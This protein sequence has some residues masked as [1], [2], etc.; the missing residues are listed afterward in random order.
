MAEVII[1][2]LSLMIRL[3]DTTNGNLIYE[4]NVIFRQNGEQIRLQQHRSG[5]WI[6][7]N[8][9]RENCIL[10][11]SVYG[12][13][14][15]EFAVDYEQLETNLPVKEVFLIPKENSTLE[16]G[17][18]T[19]QGVL[20]GIS[21]LMAVP[22]MMND[23]FTREYEERKRIIT[24]LNLHHRLLDHKYYGIVPPSQQTFE[25]VEI[26]EQ[27]NVTTIRL[28]DKLQKEFET[29]SAVVRIVYGQ[30][31][32]DGYYLM[33]VADN[34]EKLMYLVRY[35]VEDRELYQILDFRNVRQL[36]AEGMEGE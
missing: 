35:T 7:L 8:S 27:P 10:Q 21:S 9:K 32:T 11:V 33:R 2:Q 20:P 30:V 12:Y 4:K 34:A 16:N 36:T 6:L 1:Q 14:D 24:L 15:M 3:I 31:S 22:L 19:L 5:S 23:C 29:N 13:E 17:P 26:D 25:V 28:K 18:K